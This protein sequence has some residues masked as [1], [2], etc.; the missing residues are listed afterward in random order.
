MGQ[1]IVWLAHSRLNLLAELVY[2]RT[3]IA[4]PGRN[5]RSEAL[6]VNPGVRA[7]LDLAGGLQIV[8]GVSVPLGIGPSRGERAV[9]FYL[10]FEHPFSLAGPTAEMPAKASDQEGRRR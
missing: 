4:G 5:D 3:T 8:P 9:L 7:A 10:S 1:S 2:A 6:T